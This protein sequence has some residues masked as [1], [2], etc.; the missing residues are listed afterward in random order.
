[1][2]E[3][4]LVNYGAALTAGR[5]L[6]GA[7]ITSHRSE[8]AVLTK[9]IRCVRQ[10]Y[11]RHSALVICDSKS[12]H[13]SNQPTL[14]S[15]LT[16]LHCACSPMPKSLCYENSFL[17]SECPITTLIDCPIITFFD[18]LITTPYERQI[19]TLIECPITTL[20]FVLDHYSLCV[21]VHYS[22]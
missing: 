21:S 12:N 1:M 7:L 4:L 5:L 8:E 19:T 3:H 22:S 13:S 18:C 9:A 20:F 16:Q 15:R 2:E 6:R 17:F 14:T 10:H 11:Y